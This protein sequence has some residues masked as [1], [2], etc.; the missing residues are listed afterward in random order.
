MLLDL[1]F[2]GTRK[3]PTYDETVLGHLSVLCFGVGVLWSI[4]S[5]DI[6][7]FTFTLFFPFLEFSKDCGAISPIT[8]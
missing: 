1:T 2:Y 7:A 4:Y 3:P 8:Y 5:L 6:N